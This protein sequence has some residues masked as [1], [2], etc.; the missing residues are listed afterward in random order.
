MGH[1]N[2]FNVGIPAIPIKGWIND[3]G[4]SEETPSLETI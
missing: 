2:G 3:E 4:A 1:I